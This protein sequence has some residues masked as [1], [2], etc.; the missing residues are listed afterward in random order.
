MVS[1]RV[2]RVG[3]RAW[4]SDLMSERESDWE[5]GLG[6][7]TAR[8]EGFEWVWSARGRLR[9]GGRPPAALGLLGE[10]PFDPEYSSNTLTV[11]LDG[12][13]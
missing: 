10:S 1:L 4:L 6:R 5:S 7:G 9:R 2:E 8:R 11:S 3:C 12:L 13:L